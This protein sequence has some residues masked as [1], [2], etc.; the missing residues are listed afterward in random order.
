MDLQKEKF[1]IHKY[2]YG[3]KT[4]VFYQIVLSS[5]KGLTAYRANMLMSIAIGPVSL[6]AQ[7]FIWRSLLNGSETVNGMSF[8]MMMT[9]YAFATL[10]HIFIGDSVAYL[11]SQQ[12]YSGSLISILLK[13][14]NHFS[15]FFFDKIGKKIFS[16]LLE[17]VPL[18]LIFILIFKINLIPY[19]LFW[20][21]ISVSIAFIHIFLMNFCIG[22]TAFWLTNN[23]SIILTI[24][25]ITSICSGLLLPL[26]FFP[27]IFQKVLF[28]LP[29][30][31]MY[32][33]PTRVMLGNYQLAGI[34]LEVPQVVL[35]QFTYLAAMLCITIFLW[36]RGL[37]KFMGVGM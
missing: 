36:K 8:D 17:V 25:F 31:F 22:L 2:S 19:E 5:L 11:L 37:K 30:N 13:P 4:K 21:V 24:G 6:A 15:Y 20:A 16:I 27:A 7:Y 12:I 3:G 14:V 10:L 29:F 23:W 9:Y 18:A 26:D 33:I 1:K 28:I 32:Y 35:L 34:S